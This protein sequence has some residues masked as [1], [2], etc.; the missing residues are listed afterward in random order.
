M[1]L[2]EFTKNNR[3]TVML[4]GLMAVVLAF[5][6]ITKGSLFWKGTLW[7]GMMMQFPE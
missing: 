5:F 1:K 3:Y 6:S 4:I 2:K 7:Q